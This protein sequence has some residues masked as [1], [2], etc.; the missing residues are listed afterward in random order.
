MVDFIQ[1]EKEMENRKNNSTGCLTI[2]ILII[3]IV[4]NFITRDV[5]LAV[6]IIISIILG[7]YFLGKLK[8][9]HESDLAHV[10]FT[11][12]ILSILAF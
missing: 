5:F 8:F 7:F 9:A 3:L 2:F 12:L 1:Y 10:S 11:R 6:W 4:I